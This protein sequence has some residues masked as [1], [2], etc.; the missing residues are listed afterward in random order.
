MLASR[1]KHAF[2]L[3]NNEID[4]LKTELEDPLVIIGGDF[5]Q[6]GIKGC[7]TESPDVVE[8]E[9][10]PPTRKGLRLDLFACNFT[11]ELTTVKTGRPLESDSCPSDHDI[12]IAQFEIQDVHKFKIIKYQTRR[13]TKKSEKLFVEEINALEWGHLRDITNATIITDAFQSK[14]S[15]LVDKHF[16]LVTRKIKSTDDPWITDYIRGLIKIRAR[17]YSENGRSPRYK[18][19][20]SCIKEE[21]SKQKKTVVRP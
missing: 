6:F 1:V 5:N 10:S 20:D 8:I 2:E 13:R 4:R 19:L 21:I 14:I 17:E 12:L 16:P 3:I 15:E 7:F 9:Q 11:K 18:W